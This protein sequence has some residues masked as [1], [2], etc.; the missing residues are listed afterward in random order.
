MSIL[1]LFFLLLL[2]I[3]GSPSSWPFDPINVA[4]FG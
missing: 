1:P 2:I 3:A 4:F